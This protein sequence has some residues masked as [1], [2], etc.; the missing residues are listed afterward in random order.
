[1]NSFLVSLCKFR[2]YNVK[3]KFKSYYKKILCIVLLRPCVR[4]IINIVIKGKNE[5]RR[6][7]GRKGRGHSEDVQIK[8]KRQWERDRA[9]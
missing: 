9:G 5:G 6:E 1:M 3:K 2:N 7:G 8:R 4:N